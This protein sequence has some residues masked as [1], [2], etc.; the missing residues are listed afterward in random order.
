MLNSFPVC[1]LIATALGFLSGI[2]VG[3]GSLLLLWL[4]LAVGMDPLQAKALNL[5]FFLPAAVISSLFRWKQGRLN[6]KALLPAI[7]AGC[8]AAFLGARIGVWAGNRYLR[9][10]F[11]GLLILTGI[12]ELLYKPKKPNR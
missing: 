12:R 1:L 2:G 7:A 6:L 9:M 3:G 5:L 8:A 4:T 11:G 10:I